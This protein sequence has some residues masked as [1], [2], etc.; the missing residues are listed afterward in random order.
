MST[1]DDSPEIE[2]EIKF[3]T[4]K[5]KMLEGQIRILDRDWAIK[6]NSQKE[7]LERTVFFKKLYKGF[8][9]QILNYED[10]VHQI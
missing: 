4:E 1:N 10:K 2:K 6:F 3:L 8:I 5:V 9:E 7:K